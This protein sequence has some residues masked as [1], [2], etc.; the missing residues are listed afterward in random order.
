MHYVFFVITQIF[1]SLH[2]Y[3]PWNF[4]ETIEGVHNFSGERDLEHILD[5]ANHTGLLVIL[6]PGPYICAEWEMVRET[7]K[8][9]KLKSTM[10]LVGDYV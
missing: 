4:H 10:I 5:L 9:A 7:V 1:D 6:R 8:V 2:R 3:V